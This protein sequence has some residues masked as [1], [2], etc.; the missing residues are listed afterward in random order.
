MMHH[1]PTIF[2]LRGRQ[3]VISLR[4]LWLFIRLGR[5]PFLVGGFIL[6][7]LGVAA[8]LYS[9]AVLDVQALVWGQVAI[10]ATQLMTHYANDYFDLAADRANTTPTYWSGGS[11]VLP[12]SGLAPRMAL[13]TALA[14]VLLAVVATLVLALVVR[15]GLLTFALLLIALAL[16]WFYSA[17]PLQL[18]S[19]GIGE[20]TTALLVPGLTPLLG[21]YLQTGTLTPLPI[22]VV[23]P[24]CCLQFAMLLAIEFPDELGDRAVGK[25]TLLVRIGAMRAARLYILTLTVA[26]LLLPVLVMAGLPFAVGIAAGATLPLA[27]WQG[28]RVQRGAWAD[29]AQ[30]NRLAFWS[31]VLLMGTAAAELAAFVGLR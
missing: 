4:R 15:P 25:N 14:L 21:Y 7:G 23:I 29:P 6:H 9:G 10:T 27:V 5:F 28:W 16:A 30:W 17:P 1:A 11:R 22:L 8:A 20:F 12:D 24:L 19:R 2:Y 26:Y 31:I 3:V 13:I 18:H